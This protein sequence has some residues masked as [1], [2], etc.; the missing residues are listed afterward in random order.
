VAGL[1]LI[2]PIVEGTAAAHAALDDT[3]RNALD[4]R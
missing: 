4:Q 3:V 2:E 1:V